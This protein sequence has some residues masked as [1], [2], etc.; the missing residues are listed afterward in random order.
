MSTSSMSTSSM[1]TSSTDPPSNGGGS[2]DN[3]KEINPLPIIM[4][5][6]GFAVIVLII[7]VILLIRRL[8]K[9]QPPTEQPQ[10]EYVDQ[11]MSMISAVIGGSV[12]PPEPQRKPSWFQRRKSGRKSKGFEDDPN[13]YDKPDD[14]DPPK[15]CRISD[16]DPYLTP[17]S[18]HAYT[19][20]PRLPHPHGAVPLPTPSRGAEPMDLTL[21][22]SG[23]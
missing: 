5:V 9:L 17:V 3:G 16:V 20:L 2:D 7:F 15:P 6:A 10:E 12:L 8:R 19:P 13:P 4:S 14:L 11:P 18:E 23:D 21:K 22:R 1:S